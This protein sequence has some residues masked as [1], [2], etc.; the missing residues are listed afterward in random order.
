MDGLPGE[1]GEQRP[2]HVLALLHDL[3]AR[4]I[5]Q[6]VEVCL[7]QRGGV[8]HGQLLEALAVQQ[9]VGLGDHLELHL[10]AYAVIRQYV[11]V[12]KNLAHAL[13]KI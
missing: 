4:K 1:H 5:H 7:G 11:G 10:F 6:V 2:E 3:F 12:C 9:L 13:L 8:V